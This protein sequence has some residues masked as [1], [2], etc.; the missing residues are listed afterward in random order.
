M[1]EVTWMIHAPRSPPPTA[2]FE[3][4]NIL[5]LIHAWVIYLQKYKYYDVGDI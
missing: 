4:L 1:N 5:F 2:H 3:I